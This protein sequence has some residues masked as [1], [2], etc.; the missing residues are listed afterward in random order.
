MMRNFRRKMKEHRKRRAAFQGK[1][2]SN[3]MSRF[4]LPDGTFY[5]DYTYN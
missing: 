4:N 2:S 3:P 5:R 1:K